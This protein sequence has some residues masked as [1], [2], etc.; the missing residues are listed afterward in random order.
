MTVVRFINQTILH[1]HKGNRSNS[2]EETSAVRDMCGATLCF[3]AITI[4]FLKNSFL[5]DQFFLDSFKIFQFYAFEIRITDT[6]CS[7]RTG[8]SDPL[9]PVAT[10]GA[11]RGTLDRKKCQLSLHLLSTNIQKPHIKLTLKS[12]CSHSSRTGCSTV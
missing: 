7:N 6:L 11:V 10:I 12:P 9:T 3:F 2:E 5:F 4:D 1:K 8:I